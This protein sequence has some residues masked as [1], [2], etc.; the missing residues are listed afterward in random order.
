MSGR[1][2]SGQDGK[3]G[4]AMSQSISCYGGQKIPSRS[5]K[6]GRLGRL[7][8]EKQRD[9]ESDHGPDEKKTMTVFDGRL[10]TLP[11]RFVQNDPGPN[12]LL[13]RTRSREEAPFPVSSQE[14]GSP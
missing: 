4:A 5:G 6:S 14:G 8:H 1:S 12:S 9:L 7:G 13:V 10:N 11:P 2:W 3:A